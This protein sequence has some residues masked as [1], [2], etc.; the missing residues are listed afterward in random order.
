MLFRL[1]NAFSAFMN[2]MNKV[3]KVYLEKYV[4][5]FINDILIYSQS[6][7][8]HGEYLSIALRENKL[9]AKVKKCKFWL[10]EVIFLGHVVSKKNL[11]NPV[12][13]EAVVKWSKPNNANEVLSF[14]GLVGYYRRF[15][16]VFLSIIALLT[17]LKQKNEKFYRF[18]N[19]KRF[20]KN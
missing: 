9:Y 16:E 20:F 2:I 8:E 3:F 4:I 17:K 6:H 13:I 18:M 10:P 1:T 14:L 19:V 12:K 5:V 7:N 15:V 11:V